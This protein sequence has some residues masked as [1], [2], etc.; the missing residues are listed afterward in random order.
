MWTQNLYVCA[1]EFVEYSDFRF[2][3]MLQFVWDTNY[4]TDY[5]KLLL[6]K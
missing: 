1:Y 2:M 4:D 5:L 3:P 6:V